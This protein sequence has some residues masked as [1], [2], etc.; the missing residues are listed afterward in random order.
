MWRGLWLRSKDY[1]SRLMEEHVA[2]MIRFQSITAW[3]AKKLTHSIEPRSC[4]IFHFV[5][6][7][8]TRIIDRGQHG[9]S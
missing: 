7:I 8:F 6:Q 4:R 2:G 9:R 3:H 1:Q 5:V